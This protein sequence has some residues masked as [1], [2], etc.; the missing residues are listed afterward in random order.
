MVWRQRIY[1]S[2]ESMEIITTYNHIPSRIL[3]IT[4]MFANTVIIS[5]IHSFIHHQQITQ[6]NTPLIYTNLNRASVLTGRAGDRECIYSANQ[7]AKQPAWEYTQTLP[8]PTNTFT[9]AEAVKKAD[10]SYQTAFFGKW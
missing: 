4:F 3:W 10:D 7:G 2:Y 8:L 5:Y 6:P 9:I 1:S